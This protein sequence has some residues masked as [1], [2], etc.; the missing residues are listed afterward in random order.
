MVTIG[1]NK[2][3]WSWKFLIVSRSMYFESCSD[4]LLI[5]NSSLSSCRG[6]ASMLTCGWFRWPIVCNA[7]YSGRLVERFNT[8][9]LKAALVLLTSVGSNPT[10]SSRFFQKSFLTSFCVRVSSTRNPSICGL[11]SVLVCVR[12]VSRFL[13]FC[14]F[15]PKISLFEISFEETCEHSAWRYACHKNLDL[16]EC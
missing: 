8:A 15:T 3:W 6:C 9:A 16:S 10:P 4:L 13:R 2:T 5:Q 14:H 11:S 7:G 1:L 12:P